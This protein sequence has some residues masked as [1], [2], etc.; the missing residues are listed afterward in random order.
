MLI[1]FDEKKKIFHLRAKNTSYVMQ[2]VRENY[3][4]HLYWGNKIRNFRNSNPIQYVN[5]AF[6]GNPN[7]QDRSFS[8]DTLPQEY[9]QYG[10]TDFRTPAYQIQLENGSTITDLRYKSHK[11]VDDKKKLV[12]LPGTYVEKQ[13]EAE[14]LEIILEDLVAGMEVQLSYTVF[15]DYD[16]ITRSVKICNVGTQTLKV[17]SCLSVNVDFRESD[18][19]LLHLYGA[20]G[21][22]RHIKRQPLNPGR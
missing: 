8:L 20:W 13:K 6:S 10:N 15:A 11:I 16:V 17:L 14:T 7:K 5:R 19:D 4:A 12:G 3:L 2:I 21:K 9:P 1:Y 22:E 18:F